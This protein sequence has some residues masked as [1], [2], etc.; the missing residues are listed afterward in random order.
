MR[1]FGVLRF[2]VA[3]GAAVACNGTA[4]F[5][6]GLDGHVVRS[7]TSPVCSPTL[8]CTAPFAADFTVSNIGVIVAH[9]H[10]DAAG[11]FYVAL[12]PGSYTI[13]PD[14]SAPIVPGQVKTVTVKSEALTTVVLD[15][16]TGI[17]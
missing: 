6:T 17:R 3:L 16:D 4:P 5:D 15:F 2:A 7:P 9:F 14:S 13:V 10:S 8:G 1:G 11:A 12:P